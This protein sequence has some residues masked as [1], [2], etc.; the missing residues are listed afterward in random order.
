MEVKADNAGIYP[1]IKAV[2]E[3][4]N[5]KFYHFGQIAMPDMKA[6]DLTIKKETVDID[7]NSSDEDIM[8]VLKANVTAIDDTTAQD[9]I[10]INAEYTKSVTVGN[11]IVKYTAQDEAGN[12]TTQYGYIHFYKD[13]QLRVSVNGVSVYREMVLMSESGAQNITV[14]TGGE[15][16]TVTYKKGIKT[17]G[18]M[19][20]GSTVLAAD[21]E[22]SETVVFTPEKSGY[23]TFV[24]KTQGR[25]SYRFVVYVK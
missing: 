3:Y 5:A 9:N 17:I 15:P 7:L 1:V 12:V 11:V 20:I 10:T 22:N 13:N 2:D 19:K 24:V 16:Y 6:P 8:A 23:Y 4:T 25:D 14:E 21:K 18:Q